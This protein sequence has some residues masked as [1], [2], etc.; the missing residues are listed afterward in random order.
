MADEVL[1]T[2]I[3]QLQMQGVNLRNKDV[4]KVNDVKLQVS[5]KI[6]SGSKKKKGVTIAYNKGTDLYDV[7]QWEVDLDYKNKTFGEKT[8]SRKLDM[9]Y[10]DQLGGFF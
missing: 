8:K 2:M 10:A 5:N 9:M 7:E 6:R 4:M 3:K 1:K